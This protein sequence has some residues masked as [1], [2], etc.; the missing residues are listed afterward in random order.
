MSTSVRTG[1]RKRGAAPPPFFY[2]TNRGSAFESKAVSGKTLRDIGHFRKSPT[3]KIIA[4]ET[5]PFSSWQNV[6]SYREEPDA[7]SARER[8]FRY[9]ESLPATHRRAARMREVLAV[10]REMHET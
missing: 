2:P 9:A 5:Y 10:L 8:G 7:L 3:R 1:M 4:D 6:P